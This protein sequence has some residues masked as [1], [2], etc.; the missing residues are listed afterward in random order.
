ML[1]PMLREQNLDRLF[2]DM[3]MPLMEVLADMERTA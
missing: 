3:E 2:R 1:A